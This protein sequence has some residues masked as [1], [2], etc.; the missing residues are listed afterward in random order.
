MK[1]PPQNGRCQ[2]G[3]E[4]GH[5]APLSL[6]L[7]GSSAVS[8]KGCA[9]KGNF[10]SMHPSEA[11]SLP[12]HHPIKTNRRCSFYTSFA[13]FCRFFMALSIHPFGFKEG[14]NIDFLSTAPLY[15]F[16][17]AIC[18]SGQVFLK[19]F[20]LRGLRLAWSPRPGH[21]SRRIRK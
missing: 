12:A 20:I 18:P 9:G 4:S 13:V 15:R 21:M 7:L 1:V 19:A 8:A 2:T 11:R 17:L 6:H 5:E 16:F 10:L 3:A 14:S